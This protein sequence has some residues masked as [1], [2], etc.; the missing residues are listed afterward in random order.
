LGEV[1]GGVGE[2]GGG[3][4]GMGVRV[5]VVSGAVRNCRSDAWVG[6]IGKLMC[7]SKLRDGV[8]GNRCGSFHI[9]L[10]YDLRYAF[11]KFSKESPAAYISSR[12]NVHR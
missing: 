12:D 3:W 11:S 1:G 2:G 5:E 9:I 10:I 8:Q 7:G 6:G 4:G